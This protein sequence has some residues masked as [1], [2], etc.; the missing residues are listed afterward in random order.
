MKRIIFSIIAAVILFTSCNNFEDINTNQDSSTKVSSSLLATGAIMAIAEPAASDNFF[1]HMYI[2]KYMSWGANLQPALYNS[3]GRE[4]FDRYKTVNDCLLMF[5]YAKDNEKKAYEALYLFIKSYILFGYTHNLGDIPYLDILQ[6]KE[7]VLKPTYTPQ[8]DVIKGILVDLDRSYELFMEAED[9]AGDPVLHGSAKGWAKIVNAF[10]MR[11]LMELSKK[12]NDETLGIKQKFNDIYNT[13]ILL[14]NSEDNLQVVFSNKQ[15]QIYPSNNT[16]Y[17]AWEYPMLST[18]LIDILKK[19]QDYRL[20]YYASPAEADISA[21]ESEDSW[22][23]YYGIDV[24]E[25]YEKTKASYTS[26]K[27]CSL[28]KRYTH[29]IPGEP[30]VVI[31][32]IEQNFLLAEAALRGWI[33]ENPDKFYKEGIKASMEF[34]SI[35]TPDDVQY[36]HGRKITEEVIS[37]QLNRQSIQLTG[38]F[39]ND[40]EKILEQKYVSLFMQTPY[41]P[42]YDYRRTGY[43]AFPINPETN[44]NFKEPNKIPVRWLYPEGEFSYN[45]E[46]VENA[47]KAQYGGLDEVNSVMWMLK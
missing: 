9:F 6:G 25:P 47:L 28:N 10:Q 15:G 12:E 45:K 5:N 17:K 43:P 46:N 8:K 26:K 31:G 11:V 18:V 29:Y 20:F 39:E 1:F 7:G 42:Y 41:L 4:N 21:G 34:V 35:N 30:Y 22:N 40:L 27:F 16:I 19:H 33:D 32:Y 37:E 3:F 23:A 14:A 36:H 13:R 2:T 44:M 24:T 38:D